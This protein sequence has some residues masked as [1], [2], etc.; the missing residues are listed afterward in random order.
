MYFVTTRLLGVKVQ[1]GIPLRGS[2]MWSGQNTLI[3]KQ[4]TD[5]IC[6]AVTI[7]S[8]VHI[9]FPMYFDRCHLH[10]AFRYSVKACAFC[11]PPAYTRFNLAQVSFDG[12]VCILTYEHHED[13]VCTKSTV[14]EMVEYVRRPRPAI[15]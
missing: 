4:Y 9:M 15:A 3:F 11:S 7:V 12:D 5:C 10:D 6:N 14:R 1:H 2:C 8:L 13:R